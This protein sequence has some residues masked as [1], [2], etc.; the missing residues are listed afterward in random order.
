MSPKEKAQELLNSMLFELDWNGE[1]ESITV[2]EAN[3]KHC[4]LI[5][6]DEILSIKG[7]VEEKDYQI[8]LEYGEEHPNYKGYWRRVKEEINKM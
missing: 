6:V 7:I 2:L 5:A 4:A 1:K 3:A 8:S